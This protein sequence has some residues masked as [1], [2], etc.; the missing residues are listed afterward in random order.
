MAIRKWDGTTDLYLR[1]RQAGMSIKDDSVFAYSINDFRTYYT[2]NISLEKS[3]TCSTCVILHLNPIVS[4]VPG[5][6]TAGSI[7]QE[8]IVIVVGGEN[9]EVVLENAQSDSRAFSSF[10]EPLR[11]TQ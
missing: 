5:L 6:S 2:H 7:C 3:S 10:I 4:L 11:T 1:K 9:P 8:E